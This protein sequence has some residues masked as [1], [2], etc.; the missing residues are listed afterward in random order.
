VQ[1]SLR[2]WYLLSFSGKS[3]ARVV[4]TQPGKMSLSIGVRMDCALPVV[5]QLD[6]PGELRVIAGLD[7][8]ALRADR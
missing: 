8:D 5:V 1:S 7:E 2:V 4:H 6:H 3:V